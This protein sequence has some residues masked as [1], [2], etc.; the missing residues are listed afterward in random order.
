MDKTVYGSGRTEQ[1]VDKDVACDEDGNTPRYL[2]ES[3]TS[4][5]EDGDS[6]DD[7]DEEAIYD[8][9]I[10]CLCLF[11]NIS[12]NMDSS[13]KSPQ[14]G[15][16]EQSSREQSSNVDE[17]VMDLSRSFD[18]WIDY[19]GAL[20]SDESRAL[21]AR[22]QGFKDIK[23]MILNL[24]EMLSDNLQHLNNPPKQGA[25]SD[26]G[27][28]L[29][30]EA[31]NSSRFAVEELHFMANVIRKSSVRNQI[32]NLSTHRSRFVESA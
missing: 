13:D 32:Y 29:R 5:E 9:T 25:D 12:R 23:N 26:E 15:Q 21:D 6:G 30:Q 16:P 17:S 11:S 14:P 4:S 27:G 18:I 22:L 10:A 7:Y 1:A 2:H 24:L 19:T 3:G 20:A 8:T 28:D 31:I